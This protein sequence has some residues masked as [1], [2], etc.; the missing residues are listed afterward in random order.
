MKIV[1]SDDFIF[2]GTG[3]KKYSEFVGRDIDRY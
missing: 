3:V 2:K 1:L